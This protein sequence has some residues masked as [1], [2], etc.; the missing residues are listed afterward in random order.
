MVAASAAL[1]SIHHALTHFLLLAFFSADPPGTTTATAALHN[2]GSPHRPC[3]TTQTGSNQR[4]KNSAA[5]VPPRK[6]Q[7]LPRR[8]TRLRLV[9][10]VHRF[11]RAHRRRHVMGYGDRALAPRPGRLSSMFSRH[12]QN[13]FQTRCMQGQL[14]NPV[15]HLLARP[16]QMD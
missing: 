11:G 2:H 8:P 15:R 9:L 16:R 4:R 5:H 1:H 10:Q 13:Y 12:L 14:R 3:F 7:T 6:S